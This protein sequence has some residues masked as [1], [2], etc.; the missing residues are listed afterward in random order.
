ME[1][2]GRVFQVWHQTAV[3][4]EGCGASP[5]INDRVLLAVIHA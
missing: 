3:A 2:L 1:T 4:V 5:G